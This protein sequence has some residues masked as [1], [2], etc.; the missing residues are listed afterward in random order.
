MSEHRK[1]N[2][3]AEYSTAIDEVIGLAE[4]EI[5]IFDFSLE[6]LGFN[7]QQRFGK[8]QEF[9]RANPEN[10]LRIVVHDTGYLEKRCPR[11]LS[12]LKLFSHNME[13]R[14][15]AP[16]LLHVYDPFCVADSEHYARRFHFDDPR[17]LYARSDLH[18][19]HGLKLR[20]GQ[21]LDGSEEG[22]FCDTSG[23]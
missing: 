15:T 14:R 22:V 18:E 6:N 13:I 19:G 3:L 21:L 23:L 20:F 2:G 8:L 12:L 9:L 16:E 17:G 5:L 7:S 11:M 4:R 10:R 1:L